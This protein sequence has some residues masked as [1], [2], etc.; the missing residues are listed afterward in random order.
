MTT[1][2][3]IEA[4]PWH[5]GQMCRQ[6]RHEH[7]QALVRMAVNSHREM[8]SCFDQSSYSRAWLID[9]R[10]GAIGGVTGSLLDPAGYVW[11]AISQDAMRYPKAV[12]REAR[13]QLAARASGGKEPTT[14][15]YWLMGYLDK[16]AP[17]C[18]VQMH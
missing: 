14:H 13:R 10:L 4:R 1:F 9:G 12:V 8:K 2:E 3:I 15:P 18:A 7:A 5:C 11:L 17:R 16:E 6:L